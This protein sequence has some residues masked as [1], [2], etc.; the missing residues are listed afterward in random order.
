MRLIS[1]LHKLEDMTRSPFEAIYGKNRHKRI[2]PICLNLISLN[3][4]LLCLM[5]VSLIF[6]GFIA[7]KKIAFFG[8]D[9]N[10]REI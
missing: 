8:N 10:I 3:I 4:N 6:A 1:N 7:I 5:A 9:L 2:L